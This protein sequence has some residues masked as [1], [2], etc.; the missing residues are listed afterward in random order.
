MRAPNCFLISGNMCRFDVTSHRAYGVVTLS[1]GIVVL[2]GS[3]L[4]G[5]VVVMLATGSSGVGRQRDGRPIG[6]FGRGRCSSVYV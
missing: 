3:P 5:S 6:G 2:V 4:V 1:V